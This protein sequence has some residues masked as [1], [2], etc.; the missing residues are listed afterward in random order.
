MFKSIAFLVLLVPAFATADA[1]K[2]RHK[3]VICDDLSM[4]MQ[5]GV[6]KP[7]APQT[8]P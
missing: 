4:L 3:A 1:Q 7:P 5:I 2:P 6:V 8:K